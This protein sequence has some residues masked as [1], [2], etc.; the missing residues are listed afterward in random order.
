MFFY[1]KDEW[2]KIRHASLVIRR[3]LDSLILVL[4]RV[5]GT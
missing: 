3:L 5:S 1:T 4:H 2:G